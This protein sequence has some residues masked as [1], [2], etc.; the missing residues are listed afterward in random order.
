MSAQLPPPATYYPF[1][2]G[3]YKIG[4]GLLPLDRDLGN[5]PRDSHV[6]QFDDELSQFRENSIRARGYGLERYAGWRD[7]PEDILDVAVRW[8]ASRLAEE[9]PHLFGLRDDDV[10]ESRL[11]GERVSLVDPDAFDSLASQL[12]EDLAIVHVDNGDDRLAAVHVTAPNYWNPAEKLGKNFVAVHAPVPGMETLNRQSQKIMRMLIGDVRYQRFA[13]GVTTDRRLDHHT[14]QPPEFRGAE[15]EWHG[16]RFEAANPQLF[17]RVERQVLASLPR[18]PAF[19]FT[20]RPYFLDCAGLS[21]THQHALASAV[22]SMGPDALRYKGLHA[23]AETIV[24]WL[25]AG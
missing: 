17:V 22:E 16:R 25:R 18:V 4:A 14:V 8:I 13:W 15:V 11:T 21:Q 12:Q 1:E 6:F 23:D 9:H 2:S 7:C 24:G 3:V 5:G 20:I 19:L 10:L